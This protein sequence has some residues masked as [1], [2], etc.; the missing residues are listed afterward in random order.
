MTDPDEYS[1]AREYVDTQFGRIAVVSKG[2]GPAAVF[3]HGL[4]LNGYQ[5]RHQLE[6][7]SDIRRCITIDL[8][9][10][11]YSEVSATQDLSF[12]AQAAMVLTTLDS[13]GIRRFDLVGSDSGGAVA[14]I[15]AVTA[16]ERIRSLTLTNADVH[17]NWPPP[18]IQGAHQ[19]AEQGKLDELFAG[20]LENPDMARGPGSL[21]AAAYEFPQRISNATLEMFLKP[22]TSTEIRRL[23]LN[24][25]L[26]SQNNRETVR[27]EPKLKQLH[28]PT[29]IMWA[30]SD[31]FFPAQWAY[32]LRD[33]LA[34]PVQVEEFH[35]A[36][37][38][39]LEE[40]YDRANR[41]IRSH[42]TKSVD[43]DQKK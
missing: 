21:T 32:W 7:L 43:S 24:R 37:L 8:M 19:A 39:F 27:I 22:I 38:F 15:A 16:P 40:H 9:G 29:L 31:V 11:G 25:F 10:L 34:G 18:A 30:M 33:T 4:P 3:L 14:Q 36:K 41:L 23:N 35:G 5:F 13:L 2:A 12:T 42:W 20:Y 17:D 1:R 28:T 26:T 6:G